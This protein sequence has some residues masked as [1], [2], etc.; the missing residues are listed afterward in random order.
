MDLWTAL[1]DVLI[2]LFAALA[3]G[4]LCE[5]LRQ[6][7]ILGY[8]LAGTL[9]GPNALDMMPNHQ[10]VAAI[11][12]LGVALLLFTIGLEFS[13]RRLRG[14]GSIAVGGGTL[15]VLLTGA[16]AT[17]ACLALGLG[18]SASVAVGAMIALSSTACVLRVLVSRAEIDSVHGRNAL[19]ILLLQDISLIPLVLIVTA[20]GGEGS[21][22]Q[23]G[24]E[25]GRAIGV[26]AVLVAVFYVLFNYLVP[27]VLST[28]GTA[29]NRELTILLAIVTVVGAAW[30]AHRV[31]LSPALGAFVAGMLLAGSP[32]ATQI[33][34]DVVS[35]RTLFVTLFFSSIGMLAD[36]AWAAEHWALVLAVVGAVVLGKAVL[37]GGVA[38]L[39]RYS[40]GHAAATG[41]CLAQ[42]GEF[43]VV[44]TE[45]ARH[46]GLIDGDLFKLIISATIMTLF[47]TPY[48][49][50]VAP[51]LAR[52]V[53]R[54]SAGGPRE[55]QP[56]GG[57]ATGDPTV[58]TAAPHSPRTDAEMADHI[59]IVG[60]GPA[61]QRVAETLMRRHKQHIVVLELNPKTA[62]AAQAYDLQTFI[63]DATRA[64][65][66]EQ[67][68]V[69]AAR[70]VAVTVP[71]P[72]TARQVIEG[73][74][75]LSPQTPIIARSRYHIHRWQLVLAGAG[76]VID[77]EE[78][79]G[80]RIAL[81]VRKTLWTDGRE[82]SSTNDA[83]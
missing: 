80:T 17:G 14:L 23:M 19:G 21:M 55:L 81:E 65:T 63:G 73:V 43:S 31:G 74:R 44:L 69:G 37:A 2:L 70:A 77:E 11:A 64:E 78:Q 36:P 72:A 51:R 66:L 52:A 49:V 79:V 59:V 45:V 83:T 13:W 35:L 22:A 61:G 5:R 47:L 53:G 67:L 8:L 26:A 16:A 28:E 6:N 15:Q 56:R 24:W 76:A 75:S 30:A 25:M 20:L 34:A 7:A 82:P 18:G 40:L 4:A 1:L 38:C 29:R 48:L 50:A 71:D 27:L 9:L 54:L 57:G 60:F 33:R 41:V 68:R 58:E 32:F 46:R 39:F 10:A 12:E 42:I 3:L 62:A